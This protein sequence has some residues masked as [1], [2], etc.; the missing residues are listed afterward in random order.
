[1][2]SKAPLA[3]PRMGASKSRGH[4]FFFHVMQASRAKMG[5]VIDPTV[6]HIPVMIHKSAVFIG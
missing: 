6:A 4:N 3:L 1:M 5:T 2:L